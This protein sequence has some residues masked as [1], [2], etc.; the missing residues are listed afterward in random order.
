MT[1]TGWIVGVL[2]FLAVV[3]GLFVAWDKRWL[4]EIREWRED[5]RD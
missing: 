5:Q 1:T 3:V 2:I 4:R